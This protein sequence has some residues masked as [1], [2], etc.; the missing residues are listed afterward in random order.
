[1]PIIFYVITFAIFFLIIGD[2]STYYLLKN[3]N[4]SLKKQLEKKDEEFLKLNSQLDKL[5]YLVKYY[6]NRNKKRD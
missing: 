5:R 6:A 4:K 1:M 2:I 3:E